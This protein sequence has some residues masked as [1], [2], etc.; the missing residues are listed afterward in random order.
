MRMNYKT[1]N[2]NSLLTTMLRIYVCVIK[3]KWIKRKEGVA[4]SHNVNQIKRMEREEQKLK[5]RGRNEW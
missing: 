3:L 5:K 1:Y 4:H 2:K